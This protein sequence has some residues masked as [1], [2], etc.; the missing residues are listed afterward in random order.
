MSNTRWLTFANSTVAIEYDDTPPTVKMMEF[1][2]RHVPF[3]EKIPPHVTYRLA[4]QDQFSLYRDNTLVYSGVDEAILAELFLGDTIYHLVDQ[5]RDGLLFH[6]AALSWQGQGVLLPA[7]S[8]SG[9]TTLTAWLLTKKLVY[10]TDEV[11]FIPQ[12]TRL[13]QTFTRPLNLKRTARTALHPVFDFD[14]YAANILSSAYADLVPPTLLG[15]AD[16]LNDLPVGLIIF[17]CYQA[18]SDFVWQPLSKG[19]AGLELMK[20]LVNARNLTEHG[21]PEIARLVRE[22]PA[23]KL[24]Y[25][26]FQQ[27]EAH[28]AEIFG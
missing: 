26:S 9:K 15:Q 19:Q 23:F 2:Y 1:L 17:P 8:G 12:Q 10:L 6:A 18:E 4:Y 22:V 7:A 21:F 28:L 16:P 14:R 5:S 25:S 24:R 11:V 20:F 27:V 3:D 13:M